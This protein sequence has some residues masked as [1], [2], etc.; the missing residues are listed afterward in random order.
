[1]SLTSDGDGSVGG[2]E[3]DLVLGLAGVVAGIFGHQAL[4]D[5]L[6]VVVLTLH[7]NARVALKQNHAETVRGVIDSV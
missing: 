1:M 2:D 5:Q 6:Q 3:A 4:D 7:L